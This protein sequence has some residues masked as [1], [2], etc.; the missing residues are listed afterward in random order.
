MIKL[1]QG[2]HLE[3]QAD[4]ELRSRVWWCC[5]I[6]DK[7][8]AE[9]TGRPVLLHARRSTTPLPSVTEADEFELWPPPSASSFLPSRNRERYDDGGRLDKSPSATVFEP[10][11]GRLL[12][13]FQTTCKL[14]VIVE[15]ILDLDEE[16]PR[17][18][19]STGTGR[20]EEEEFQKKSM[21]TALRKKD[22]LA[23]ALTDWYS[24][25]PDQLNVDVSIPRPAPTH[26]IVNLAVSARAITISSADSELKVIPITVVS[27]GCDSAPLTIHLLE[28]RTK[29]DDRTESNWTVWRMPYAMC[30]CC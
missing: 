1:L 5:Y 20:D 26:L 24:V 11:Q 28:A 3:S 12:S 10:A 30:K 18:E 17:Y 2:N 4:E 19:R 7:V 13:A 29:S 14:G 22:A 23:K 25:L 21:E 8:L 6:L 27:F 16:G 15:E 9:E